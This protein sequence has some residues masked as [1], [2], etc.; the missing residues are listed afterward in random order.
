ML[1]HFVTYDF[2]NAVLKLVFQ[3]YVMLFCCLSLQYRNT[4]PHI[5]QAPEVFHQMLVSQ[6]Q[7]TSV[8]D[9]ARLNSAL[10]DLQLSQPD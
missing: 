7:L 1:G 5:L 4:V 10:D 6:L 8:L 2:I 9:V 3:I